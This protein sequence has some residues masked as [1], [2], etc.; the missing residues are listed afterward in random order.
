MMSVKSFIRASTDP[1]PLAAKV[2]QKY[3]EVRRIILEELKQ[4]SNPGTMVIR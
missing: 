1:K 4:H 2:A 3:I